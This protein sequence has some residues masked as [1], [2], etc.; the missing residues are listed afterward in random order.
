MKY[1]VRMEKRK[2]TASR[3]GKYKL[4][5]WFDTAREAREYI[6]FNGNR[7]RTYAV[8]EDTWCRGVQQGGQKPKF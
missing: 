2:P 5:K 1:S 8:F 6:E 4:L 3:P 7:R